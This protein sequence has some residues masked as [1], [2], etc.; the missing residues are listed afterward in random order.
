MFV[1]CTKQLIE[2]SVVLVVI[3]LPAHLNY[4]M[5]PA[6]AVSEYCS[7]THTHTIFPTGTR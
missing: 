6:A 3:R 1:C 7:H 2:T 5:R 4:G